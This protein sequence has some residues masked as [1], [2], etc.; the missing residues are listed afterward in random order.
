MLSIE[1]DGLVHLCRGEVVGEGEGQAEE[2]GD[3]GSKGRR[4]EDPHL[5][6]VTAAGHRCRLGGWAIGV[7]QVVDELH[8]ILGKAFGGQVGVPS[9]RSGR[10]WVGAWRSAE[11][12][13][14]PSRM[15][16]LE[17]GE[18]LGHD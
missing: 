16:R 10:G 5:R 7:D 6:Q 3:L 15:E 2:T 9:Q 18:L 11:P 17:G 14:D 12:K 1:G 13:I 4:T 8:N